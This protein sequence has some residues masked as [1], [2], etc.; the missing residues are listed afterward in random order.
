MEFLLVFLV[1][2]QWYTEIAGTCVPV[3]LALVDGN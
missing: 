2:E 1:T 3:A